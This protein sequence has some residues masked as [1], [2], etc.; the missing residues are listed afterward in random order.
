MPTPEPVYI[1]HLTSAQAQ[2]ALGSLFA[3]ALDGRI[4]ADV[5]NAIIDRAANYR[6][7]VAA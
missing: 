4:P 2:F 6:Q 7:Q 3:A 1:D 5:W